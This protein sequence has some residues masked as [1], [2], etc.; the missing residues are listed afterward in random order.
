MGPNQLAKT[1]THLADCFEDALKRLEE[2]VHLLEEGDVGLDEAWNG[3]RK[4]SSCCGSRTRFSQRAERRIELLSG[5]D[6]EG[7]P[8]TAAVRRHGHD[9]P[10]RRKSRAASA[11]ALRPAPR[12]TPKDKGR[13]RSGAGAWTSRR[14]DGSQWTGWWCE[15]CVSR[16]S[17]GWCVSRTHTIVKHVVAIRFSEIAQSLGRGSTRP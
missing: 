7:N 5:V 1:M 6:A 10:G 11:D 9:R 8:I 16:H 14:G 3:M 15:W 12:P 13:I 2:I 17:Y 4:G